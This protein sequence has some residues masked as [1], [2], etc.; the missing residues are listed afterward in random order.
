MSLA[1]V[2][3][4]AGNAAVEQ[5]AKNAGFDV[6][7]PFK[8]G[9]T[10]ASQEQTD[11]TSFAVL[12]PAADGFRNYYAAGQSRSPAELLVDKANLLTL[13]VPEMTVL[14]GGMRALNANTGEVA[15]G[16]FTDKPGTLTNDF[17]VNLLDM[18]TQWTKAKT[19]GLYEG[20]DRKTGQGQVDGHAG[21]PHLR[22]ERRA[23]RRGRGLRPV[24][25][26]GE[27]RARLRQGLG[28]GDQ[29]RPLRRRPEVSERRRP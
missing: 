22:V 12:E 29:P 27:V 7:V 28:Q 21:R 23:T 15:H 2:I 6:Q 25:R 10:D 24:R 3:V 8:P 20:R 19:E 11:V 13:T 26:Q 17:F 14:V 16:V 4:L 1:D 5:A 18:S 9:R